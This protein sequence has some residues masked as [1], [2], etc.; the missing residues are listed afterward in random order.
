LLISILVSSFFWYNPNLTRAA[1]YNWIQTDWSGG[2]S[3]ATASHP[4]NQ[5]GW[6]YY[7][8]ASITL[9]IGTEIKLATT[10]SSIVQTT[11][12]DF[13]SGTFNNT[14]VSGTGTAASIILDPDPL[15]DTLKILNPYS[16]PEKGKIWEVKF[17]TKGKDYLSILPIRGTQFGEDLQFEG[18]YCGEKLVLSENP[19][20]GY[21]YYHNWQCDK[22]AF[23]RSKVLTAGAHYLKFNFGGVTKIA[24]N[25]VCDSGTL[26]TTCYVTSTQDVS[27]ETISGSGNLVIQSGGSLT[28]GNATSTNINMGGDITIESENG[29]NGNFNVTCTNLT[30]N[31]GASINANGKGYTGGEGPGQGSDSGYA[32]GGAGYGGNGG[33]SSNGISGGSSYGSLTTPTDL[34]SG[35]GNAQPYDGPGGSGGGAIY[36]NVSETLTINGSITANGNNGGAHEGN[37]AAAGGGSGGSIY[38]ITETL[39]G[40]GTI[41]ANGGNGGDTSNRDGGGGAGGRIAIYYTTKTFNGNITAYGGWGG[42]YGGAGTI[43]LKSSTQTYGDLIIDNNGNS[44]KYTYTLGNY[45]FDNLTIQNEGG[46]HIQ[47]GE[48][49]T[50][51]NSDFDLAGALY[52]E[53]TFSAS[54]ASSLTVNGTFTNSGTFNANSATSLTVNN[55][56]TNSGNFNVNGITTLT[57]NADVTNSNVFNATSLSSITISSGATFTVNTFSSSTTNFP[58]LADLTINGTL[59]HFSNTNTKTYYIELSLTN[60]TINTGGEINANGKGYTGGEGPGQGSDSGYAGGGAGYGGNGGD[61]SN[62]ISGGSSYGSLTTPTDLGSGGGNAQPYDGPGGSGGGAIYLNVSETLTINGSIT[63]NGNNGGAHEGNSAA[64]GGGSGGSIYII[65]ETLT[66]SGTITANGGNGGD[67]SNRDGGG[68]AGG[69]IAIY[70]KTDN[71]TGTI[72]ANGGWGGQYGE[73][74][75][76]YIDVAYLSSGN[77]ISSSIY[78]GKGATTLSWSASTPTSTAIKFQLSSS[79]DGTSWTDFVGPDGSTSTYYTTPGTTVSSVHNGHKYIR[80]KVY[81]S[82]NDRSETPSLLDVTINYV[83][84]SSSGT[85]ISSPYNTSDIA[86][87]LAGISWTEDL[88]SGT[89]IKFQVRTSPDGSNWTSWCGP[90]D[91]DNSTSTCATSTYFTDPNGGEAMDEMFTDGVDDQW[92]QYKVILETTDVSQTPTLSD[93]TLTYVVNAPPEFD[94]SYGTN[95]ISINVISSS[96][97]EISYKVRDP[98]TNEASPENQWKLWPSFEYSL[99]GGAN[100]SSIPTSTLIS[101]PTLDNPVQLGPAT[102]TWVT[103]TTVWDAKSLIPGNYSTTAKIRVTIDDHEAANNTASQT[104][105]NFILDTK[106]PTLGSVPIS[107]DA[108]QS[109]AL[110]T[111]S[112]SDDSDL[113]MR[114]SLNSDFSDTSWQDYSS[115]TTISL[116]TDPDTVYVQFK[117]EYSN[118]SSIFSATT[119]ETPTAVMIQDTSNMKLSPAEYRLFIAWK[120]VENPPS[121]SFLRYNILR[122]DDGGNSYSKIAEV[123]NQNTNYYADNTVSFDTVYYYK[124]T[125]EDQNHNISFLSSA[126]YGKANGTQDAGEGG[127]GSDTTAPTI[128]NVATS[129]ITTNSVTITWDTDELSNSTVG[130][131]T[132]PGDFTNEVG[133]AT[134]VNNSNGV[135]QH[136][137]TLTGLTPNTTYYFQVKSTDPSGNIATSIPDANGYTFTTLPGPAV[138]QGSV[139]V[140]E[141]TNNTAKITWQTDKNSNSYVAFATSTSILESSPEIQGTDDSTTNHSVTLTG[142]T[143]GTKYYFYVKS[144]DSNNNTAYDKNVVDGVIEYYTFTTGQ[145]TTPPVISDVSSSVSTSTAVITWKTNELA[146]SR[147]EYGKTTNYGSLATSSTLTIDHV[148]NLS[149]LDP[150]TTYHYR[151]ISTDANNNTATSTDYTF[152]T[153]PPDDTTPPSITNVTVSS[154][155][156]T[157][158]IITWNTDENSNSIVD[159]GETTSLGQMAGN[160]DDSTTAHSVTLTNLNASTTYYFQVRSQDL[161]GNTATDNNSGNYYSFVTQKDTTPPTIS[162]VSV[163][164]VSD[165]KATITW[166]TNELSTSQVI[167]GTTDSYGSQTEEDTTLTYQHSVTLTGLTKKTTYHYQVVSKDAAG[168]S[169]SSEDNTFTTTD[170]PGIVETITQGGGVLIIEKETKPDESP[171]VISDIK[172]EKVNYTSATISWKTNEKTDSFIEYGTTT[173]YEEGVFGK[174]ESTISH[175]LT[176]T[177]LTPGTTYHFK[178]LGKDN[179]GNLGSSA[180]KT[181]T[182]LRRTAEISE[183]AIPEKEKSLVKKAVEILT[184]LSNPHSLASVSEVLEESAQRVI[185]PPMIAGESPYVEVGSDWAQITWLTDK[186]SNSLVAYAEEDEYHPERKE[187]YAIVAGNPDEMV[188]THIVELVN[189]K[190]STVYHFQV[191]SKGKIGGWAKSKDKTFKTL[192]LLPKISDI[193]FISIKDTEAELSWLTSIPTR[194]KI[195]V[196]NTKTGE[197]TIQEDKNFLISHIFTIKNLQVATDYTL[198]I[199]AY[200]EK[201]NEAVSSMIPFS[202]SISKNPPIISSI[203]IATALIPGRIERVQAI[204]TWRTDKPATS[205]VYYQEGLARKGELPLK[206]PLDKKLVLDHIVVTTSFKPG[207]VYQFKVESIDSFGN[208][209]LSK[210]YVILTPQ[211][212]QNVI[213]LIIKNFEETFGFLKRLKF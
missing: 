207:K 7:Q 35:G 140:E 26:D 197:K 200:D 80:Y 95:G 195:I 90:D 161:A 121:A 20:Q 205:R 87:I 116:E 138:V 94:T 31:S 157:S 73:N 4:D 34:G 47:A 92:I 36:L 18:L 171:P 141:V 25:F 3:T 150:S 38:I 12:T 204:I 75:T 160:L 151:V 209:T 109:P 89:D 113:Y 104:S 175:S 183:E 21:I 44:G 170:E 5:T 28:T 37:S 153:Q 155:D 100:W 193:K 66:G 115:S 19:N 13:G 56:L 137:V 77:F 120:K 182:T 118:S 187:P 85:L 126:V 50:A 8:S 16:H 10:T 22:T 159:Y 131:S 86:N 166:T 142:L 105:A 52:N 128:S 72:T 93:V 32:G 91:A 210:P 42:Q 119:P 106:N 40:S 162:N 123:T 102:S 156:L 191:R 74:G 147:V 145:D 23:L 206:T 158:A 107:V 208:R 96:Q 2:A 177:N 154:V 58:N 41:T 132:T 14:V 213:T 30:I 122:S 57:I 179:Y 88:P 201:G 149:N 29:L 181:F 199:K 127:G 167:Y 129:S 163:S 114:I 53:G 185:S 188:T 168:N 43:Y 63:A 27:G 190:P 69:R 133:V 15:P 169:A 117:D 198:Q 60:L 178:A 172:I 79:P 54:N 176:L 55:T 146:N 165:T 211:P 11:D 108:S 164:T 184:K 139:V 186:K 99:D 101:G 202:T 81:L 9:N 51:L 59:T 46:L 148:I 189:L 173:D 65:T 62:G 196:T 112:A 97:V 180:D 83:C 143:E 194:S 39:T 49:I 68:G 135:G 45:T 6:T 103:A 84:Y 124:V 152:T 17:K 174:Y 98:D 1:T 136:S 144:T 67:T 78:V 70:R 192:S 24:H 212:K 125:T 134:M 64:A 203:R 110:I 33:D 61:S 82:T 71:F 76:I 111:L 130:Y 48:S